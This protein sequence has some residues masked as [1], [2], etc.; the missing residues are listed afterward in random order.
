MSDAP[1]ADVEPEAL[2][3]RLVDAGV[4]DEAPDGELTAT[5]PFESVHAVYRDTYLEVDDERF[6]GT[7][8]EVFDVDEAEAA[9]R[10]EEL[11]VTRAEL[12]AY[13]ALGSFLEESPPPVELATMAAIVVEVAPPSPVPVGQRELADDD[14]ES[15]LA[16][17]PDAVLFVWRRDCAPCDRMKGDLDALLDRLP[18]NGAVAGI[19]GGSADAFR[20]AFAVDAAPTT[21]VFRDGDLAARESGRLRPGEFADLLARA[22][23]RS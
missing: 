21:L 18:A 15:F 17:H 5:R 8:A 3:D 14:Y 13:L 4:V 6:R 10:I 16:D 7:V 23:G 20:E 1:P 19:D 9:T 12:A 22:D 2:L 11:G